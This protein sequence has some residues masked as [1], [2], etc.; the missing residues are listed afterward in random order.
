MECKEFVKSLADPFH[1]KNCRRTL[2]EHK[3]TAAQAESFDFITVVLDR[4]G[5]MQSVKEKTIAGFNSYLDDQRSA[6][7]ALFTLVQFDDEY[8]VLFDAVPI[9]TVEHRDGVNYQPRGSTALLDAMGKAIGASAERVSKL[10]SKPKAIIVSVITDGQENASKEFR[11]EEG[12]KRIF[13]M[14]DEH[15]KQGWQCFFIG[16]EPKAIEDA[17]RHYGFS[18]S[19]TAAYDAAAPDE[20]FTRLSRSNINARAGQT[21]GFNDSTASSKQKKASRS[22]TQKPKTNRPR[23]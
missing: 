14:I 4:S 7:K 11:G 3:S 9:E 20:A 1:C 2:E 18:T 8:E 5:S 23:A 22:K 10:E 19:H 12:R 6:G 17:V 13:E 16:A 15:K 21:T